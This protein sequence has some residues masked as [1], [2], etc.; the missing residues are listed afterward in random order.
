MVN[1]IKSCVFISGNGSNLKS[2]IKSSRDYNFPIKIELV[3]SNNIKAKGIE[4]AKKHGIP[5]KFFAFDNQTKFERNSL[6]EIRKRK[7][8]FLCLAG[9]M[10]ILSRS[11]IKN[12]GYKIINI[13]PS[14]L[15]KF[16]GLNTHKRVLKSNEKY[17]GCTVHFISPKLDSGK[18]ILQKKVLISK[19]ETENSLR[20]KIL[21]NEHKI[22]SQSII[23]IFK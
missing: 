21:Q 17:S 4:L 12:F 3:I 23:S 5:F 8:K 9:F 19:S 13:H 15:P 22:Y 7:I 11:F 16:K 20:K 2:L 1:K 18:I 14:L 10:K 6:Y